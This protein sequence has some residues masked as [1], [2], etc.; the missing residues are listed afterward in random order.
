MEKT[1]YLLLTPAY[2][3]IGDQAIAW[4]EERWLAARYPDRRLCVLD[5]EQTLRC[6]PG[7]LAESPPD[8]LFFLQ[9]GGNLGTLYP[10]VEERRRQ[11]IRTLGTRPAVLFPQSVWFENEEAA[12]QS[13]ETYSR[14]NLTLFAREK[15]SLSLMERWYPRAKVCLRPDIVYSLWPT[16]RRRDLPRTRVLVSLR[17][18][19]E[20][21]FPDRRQALLEKLRVVWPEMEEYKMYR[22]GTVGPEQRAALVEQTVQTFNTA[23]LIVTDRLHGV[24]FAAVTGTPCVALPNAYYKNREN[25]GAWLRGVNYIAFCPDADP[26]QVAVLA[27]QVTAVAEEEKTQLMKTGWEIHAAHESN[28]S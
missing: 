3:S 2:A 27:Q 17:A 12:R 8:T 18:D 9:G 15:G 6:L 25:Y 16:V 13:A 11:V 22:G 21:A 20:S 10:A 4:A 28:P 5:E 19:K 14:P 1:I 26:E 24:I 7:I 23:R